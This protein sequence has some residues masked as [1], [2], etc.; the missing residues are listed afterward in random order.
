MNVSAKTNG[1]WIVMTV[2]GRLDA[3]TSPE[4]EKE[5]NAWLARG[6]AKNLLLDM[7]EL[8]YISSAGLRIILAASKKLKAAGGKIALS[9]LQPLVMDV[10]RISGFES[11]IPIF[12]S[13]DEAMQ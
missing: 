13:P 11:V 8:P 4:L 6:E 3:T 7:A 12:A 5:I 2:S 10:F 9:G 1:D